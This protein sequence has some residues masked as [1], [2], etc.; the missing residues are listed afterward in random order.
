MALGKLALGC[1]ALALS[2]AAAA[3]SALDRATRATQ[4]ESDRPAA[5]VAS[6]VPVPVP[7]DVADD[8]A[9]PPVAPGEAPVAVGAIRLVG[10]QVLT[11]ADFSDILGDYVGKNCSTADLQALATRLTQ[12]ARAR[13]Y[14]FAS[15]TIAPQ[16]LVAGM[17]AAYVDEGRVAR[18]RIEGSDRAALHATLD[19]LANGKPVTMAELERQL[20]LA[21]DIDGIAIRHT[22]FAREQG[23]GVLTVQVSANRVRG[24]VVVSNDG[25]RPFGP[26]QVRI[27]IGAGSLLTADDWVSFT[28]G[29]SFEPGEVAYAKL[30]YKLR[31]GAS[32]TELALSGS[33]SATHPGS[34]LEPYD[35]VGHDAFLGVSILQPLLRRR[36]RSMWLSAGLDLRDA[37]QWSQG[38]G[39]QR[40]RIVAARLGLYG[41]ERF[42]GGNLRYNA[43]L[44]QGLPLFD[45]SNAD[46]GASRWLARDDFTSASIWADWTRPIGGRF[47][48]KLAGQVQVASGPLFI[49]EQIGLGGGPFLR[50]Y[51]YSERSGDE[52]VMGSGELQ[53]SLPTSDAGTVRRAQIYAFVDGGKV[54]YLGGGCCGGTLASGGG[55]LRADLAHGLGATI[56]VAVPM[57]GPRYDTGHADP[58]VNFAIAKSF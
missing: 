43:L 18:V 42:A 10:L 45:A 55:G 4:G 47:G 57:T 37:R 32:G 28:L 15:A 20:M 38:I 19:P 31:V 1:A 34:Y 23:L 36:S 48:V 50:G 21:S 8:V 49:A 51:D 9:P 16:R 46:L 17:L 14:V 39:I 30:R 12:R 52:G 3:Q 41:Y 53:Y 27:E 25:T 35:L 13:G 11:P 5:P 26:E 7:V 40:D 2:G 54:E 6:V 22:S 29:S 58:K 24:R 44:S 56:E 33:F